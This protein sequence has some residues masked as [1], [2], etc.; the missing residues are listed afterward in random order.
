[1]KIKV[2]PV[3]G[4]YNPVKE[5]YCQSP[6]CGA[7]L[8]NTEITD[9]RET[10][11]APVQEGEPADKGTAVGPGTYRLCPECGC[12]VPPNTWK[13]GRC[14]CMLYG[15]PLVAEGKCTENS[16]AHE[17]IFPD[18]LLRSEDGRVSIPV[19]EGES[20]VVG[21]EAAGAEYLADRFYVGRKH[22]KFHAAEGWVHI[23]DMSST[24][25]TLVNGKAL[26]ADTPFKLSENDLISLGA[27]EGQE[28]LK[29]AAY[30]KLF[31]AEKEA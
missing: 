29:N 20:V 23:T 26:K 16:E 24:N 31:K 1:M 30:F 15:L 14:G 25:G 7:S 2:C 13:C 8:L 18:Y 12:H 28:P 21:R 4:F 6:N 22:A 5:Q 27:K 17:P 10:A 11:S 9:D 19:H 3:C